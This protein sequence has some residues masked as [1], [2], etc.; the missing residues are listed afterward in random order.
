MKKKRKG[1]EVR[2]SRQNEAQEE[3]ALV[4]VKGRWGIRT[5][6]QTDRHTSLDMMTEPERITETDTQTDR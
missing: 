5:D 3:H 1:R 6:R 4:K 2:W